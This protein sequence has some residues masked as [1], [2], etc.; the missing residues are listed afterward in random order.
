MTTRI[1]KH[2]CRVETEYDDV[3]IGMEEACTALRVYGD[4]LINCLM[5]LLILL[6]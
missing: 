4:V 3:R 6:F 1:T 5:Q 2:E